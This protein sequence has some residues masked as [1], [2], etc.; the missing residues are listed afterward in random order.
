MRKKTKSKKTKQKQK[1]KQSQNV[2][3]TVTVNLGNISKRRPQR[4]TGT[5]TGPMVTYQQMPIPLAPSIDYGKLEHTISSLQNNILHS[6]NNRENNNLRTTPPVQTPTPRVNLATPEPRVQPNSQGYTGTIPP[7]RDSTYSFTS[8]Y[9]RQR[10]E[11]Y[12]RL[13]QNRLAITQPTIPQSTIPPLKAE[14]RQQAL[15]RLAIQR[16]KEEDRLESQRLFGTGQQ[17][18]DDALKEI[19]KAMSFKKKP[20]PPPSPKPAEPLPDTFVSQNSTKKLK[21]VKK[22]PAIKKQRPLT[23]EPSS[24]I[25][26]RPSTPEKERKPQLTG[27]FKATTPSPKK[28]GRPKGSKNKPKETTYFPKKKD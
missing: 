8:P 18:A 7:Q 2:R 22:E 9:S 1:Q 12:N 4:R 3:Q 25:V 21:E 5:R 17:Q 19:K 10:E 23:P 20:S 27:E 24:E 15:Q 13:S 28:R 11:A 6:I 16:Q 14:V 26:L